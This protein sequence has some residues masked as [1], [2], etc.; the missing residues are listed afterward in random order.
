M[1]GGSWDYLCYK[2]EEAASRLKG[3]KCEYRRAFGNHMELVAKAMHDI[4]WVDSC[5]YSRGDEIEAIQAAMGGASQANA[6]A[7]EILN[8]DAQALVEKITKLTAPSE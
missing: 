3:E 6:A 5:D 7:L 8:L 4:E 1:S 2:L